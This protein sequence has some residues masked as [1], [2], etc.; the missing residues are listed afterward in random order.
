MKWYIVDVSTCWTTKYRVCHT[1]YL[2]YELTN[3]S[4]ARRLLYKLNNLQ[5]H[6]KQ[7]NKKIFKSGDVVYYIRNNEIKRSLVYYY[8]PVDDTCFLQIEGMNKYKSSELFHTRNEAILKI[9]K[10]LIK[11]LENE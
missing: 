10:T 9:F 3:V 4:D 2:S 5:S 1:D 8:D 7:T 11:E 6:E